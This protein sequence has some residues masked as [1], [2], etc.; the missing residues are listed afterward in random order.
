[1]R[2]NILHHVPSPG[3]LRRT[4]RKAVF[5]KRVRCPWC[6]SY[7][8]RSIRREERWRCNSCD[9]PFS[10]TSSCWL[11]G[12]KLP[13][14]TIWLLLHCWQKKYPLLHAM[15]ITGVSYPTARR[16]YGLFRKHIPAE[17]LDILLSGNIAADEMFT[18]DTAIMGAKQKGTRNVAFTVLHEK[19]PNKGHAVDF[20]QRFT[21]V[22]SRLF[23]DGSAIYRSIGN[24][25]RLKHQYEIHSKFEFALTAEIEGVWGCFRT[26]VRRVYH[27]CTVYKL[28][29]MV[30]EFCLRFR[31]DE[32]FDSPQQ[33]WEICLSPK[34]FAL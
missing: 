11:R 9:K 1:M 26:F 27:H 7:S 15:D 6:R 22:N 2:K 3:T 18:R 19:H 32:I 28:E 23:T 5:G 4:L 24:W 31:R 34:P 16:W 20:L 8:F 21:K 33:Y 25:H 30:K 17:R 29:D 14:E 10:I 12:S 13:L